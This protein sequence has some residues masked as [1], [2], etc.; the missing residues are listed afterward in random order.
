MRLEI[1]DGRLRLFN[2][3]TDIK[4]VDYAF[5]VTTL[6]RGEHI[7]TAEDI[8]QAIKITTLG[9]PCQDMQN[10][11]RSCLRCNGNSAILTVIN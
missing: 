5:A 9:K 1:K 8:G 7:I 6:P 10:I 3:D 4:P 2:Y 11:I